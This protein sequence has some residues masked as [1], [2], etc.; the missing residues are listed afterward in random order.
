MLRGMG[1]RRNESRGHRWLIGAVS[2]LIDPLQAAARQRLLHIPGR[3]RT[4]NPIEPTVQQGH[5]QVAQGR[6]IRQRTLGREKTLRS[7][8]MALQAVLGQQGGVPSGA[9]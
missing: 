7:Q 3:L 6:A 4:A 5:R 1:N 9:R 2:S 8:V